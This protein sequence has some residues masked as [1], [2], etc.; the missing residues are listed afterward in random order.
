MSKWFM[1]VFTKEFKLY[2][3]IMLWDHILCELDDKNELL[4]YIA[5]AIIHWL[6]E[7]LLKGEFGEVITIL[8]NLEN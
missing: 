8:Q 4:N 7:D 6:R 3:T 2:D 1:T 5:L